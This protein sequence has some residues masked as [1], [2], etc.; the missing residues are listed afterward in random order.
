[1]RRC[2][3][4]KPTLYEWMA[5]AVGMGKGWEVTWEFRNNHVWDKKF[6]TEAEALAFVERSI[7]DDPNVLSWNIKEV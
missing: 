1:M 6:L 5:H 2:E 4:E 7:D 3:M